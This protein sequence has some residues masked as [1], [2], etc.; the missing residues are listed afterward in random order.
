MMDVFT[1]PTPNGIQMRQE[2]TSRI[3]QRD[4][5]RRGIERCQTG[6]SI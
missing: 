2:W 6:N 3:E 4:A 1:S 5:V